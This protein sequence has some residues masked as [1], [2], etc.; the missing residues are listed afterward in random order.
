MMLAPSS[1]MTPH[2]KLLDHTCKVPAPCKV[3]FTGS[4]APPPTPDKGAGSLKM[5]RMLDSC[6]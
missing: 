1:R 4:E 6:N 3:T 2:L 5:N